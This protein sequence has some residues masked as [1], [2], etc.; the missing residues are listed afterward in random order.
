MLRSSLLMP[1]PR[2]RQTN[3]PL[4]ATQDFI[5]VH[6]LIA[7]FDDRAALGLKRFMRQAFVFRRKKA[8]RCAGILRFGVFHL[9]DVVCVLD[10]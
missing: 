2:F 10:L 4:D 3:V 9:T 6:L 8:Q 5:A 7:E 1:Q